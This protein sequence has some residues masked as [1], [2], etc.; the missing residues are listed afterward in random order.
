MLHFSCSCRRNDLGH[1]VMFSFYDYANWSDVLGRFHQLYLNDTVD[2]HSAV[3]TCN[4]SVNS[5]SLG[6][7]RHM[8]ATLDCVNP[9]SHD[10]CKEC[11]NMLC[12]HVASM[13]QSA[14]EW[15]RLFSNSIFATFSFCNP[16]RPKFFLALGLRSCVSS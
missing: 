13:Y 2:T 11:R 7:W 4:Y 5:P 6:K 10:H 12:F 14:D 8:K 15:I 16:I 3:Q 9:Y 1:W